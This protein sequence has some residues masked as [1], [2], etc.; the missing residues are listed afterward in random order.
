MAKFF[1]EPLAY[2][3]L[4]MP[5]HYDTTE[6]RKRWDSLIRVMFYNPQKIY[7]R[8]GYLINPYE[9]IQSKLNLELLFP[10][11]TDKICRCGCERPCKRSWHDVHCST[12]AFRVYSIICYGTNTIQPLMKLYY[13]SKCQMCNEDYWEDIDHVIPVKHGGGGCWL[14]N[15]KPVCKSCHKDK[16][17][18]DFKWKEYK[19]DNQETLN[20]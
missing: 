13:G 16:T 8:V 18:K 1:N 10:K 4:V 19:T 2:K 9:R 6:G 14:S 5:E 3:E 15:Y 12:F 7:N 11:R 20:L 17:K